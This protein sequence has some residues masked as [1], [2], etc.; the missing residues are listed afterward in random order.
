[1][2]ASGGPPRCPALSGQLAAAAAAEA[3]F[4]TLAGPKIGMWV[5]LS[6]SS[7]ALAGPMVQDR[8]SALRVL[9]NTGSRHYYNIDF[10]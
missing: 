10:A 7:A 2:P 8:R 6:V 3:G 1:M 5:L 4:R 9:E